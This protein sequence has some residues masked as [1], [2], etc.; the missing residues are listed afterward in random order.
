MMRHLPPD[1][2][3]ARA[4]CDCPR[5]ADGDDRKFMYRIK[6]YNWA[7]G[8]H[9]SGRSGT[10]YM[11]EQVRMIATTKCLEDANLIAEA[12]NTQ[13][14]LKARVELLEGKL[15][16]TITP[17]LVR[18]AMIEE[19]SALA[20]CRWSTHRKQIVDFGKAVLRRLGVDS[21]LPT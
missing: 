15:I 20:H 3:P 14:R 18:M 21:T 16:S 12:L 5:C 4:R 7:H 2:E 1:P 13:R 8:V 9:P 19:V 11:I 17:N 6:P 10:S